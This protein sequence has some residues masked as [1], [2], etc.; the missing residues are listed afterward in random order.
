M[1]KILKIKFAG[2]GI[3]EKPC[4]I[5]N[6]GTLF[7]S[8]PYEYLTNLKYIADDG[9]VEP[10][11]GTLTHTAVDESGS[12]YVTGFE[13]RTYDLRQ[14]NESSV[15]L[16]KMSEKETYAFGTINF[17]LNFLI[18]DLKEFSLHGKRLGSSVYPD[19][20]VH[21]GDF[22]LGS[23]RDFIPHMWG[24]KKFPFAESLYVVIRDNLMAIS[25]DGKRRE[26]LLGDVICTRLDNATVEIL[27]PM[28]ELS[29]ET[30]AKRF[31]NEPINIKEGKMLVLELSDVLDDEMI[32]FFDGIS[33]YR[34][35]KCRHTLR[36]LLLVLGR[37]SSIIK[38]DKNVPSQS[39]G[40]NQ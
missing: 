38:V 40:V 31:V 20:E 24:E 4:F 12:V 1:E 5:V 32:L 15:V 2:K 22:N 13:F 14:L 34:Y 23:L 18:D 36:Y 27:L 9:K 33:W 17:V 37:L 21:Y 26:A 10:L 30:L 39:N 3:I 29:C 6:Y 7:T 28:L 11:M 35:S 8:I 16:V 19:I 25:N